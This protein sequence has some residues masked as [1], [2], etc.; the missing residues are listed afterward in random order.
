MLKRLKTSAL[1][2]TMAVN[3][4]FIAIMIATGYGDR[5][6]PAE[7]ATL[8][9]LTLGFPVAVAANVVWLLFWLVAKWRL[10]VVPLLGF[11]LC[12]EPL[13]TYFPIHIP[14][15]PDDGDLEI[16]TF[17]VKNFS[18]NDGDDPALA[19]SEI[20]DYLVDSRADIICLQ[21]SSGRVG[22]SQLADTLKASGRQCVNVEQAGNVLTF[23]SPHRI[24]SVRHIRYKSDANMSIA[25]WLL[26]DG[27]TVVVVN[28]HL[29]SNL[30][31]RD[32]KDGFQNI[33]H[34]QLSTADTRSE[35]RHLLAKLN[36]AARLRGPQA[37]AVHAFVDSLQQ[38]GLPVIV[39]G[40]FN[41]H[42]LSYV[43]RTIAQGL[44]DAYKATGCGPG[45]SYHKSGMYVRIDH[46]LCS[47]DWEPQAAEVDTKIGAS[48][49][50]PLRCWLK[51]RLKR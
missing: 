43:R 3:I 48:D 12:F 14:Q 8:A 36:A 18:G 11:A 19:C 33:V 15:T 20:I 31:N 37:D 1:V 4:V 38:R 42:P 5:L 28:N 44:T 34:G 27:D 26:V 23:I 41:D 6:S 16:L 32:D 49:H 39:C 22:L 51:K 24:L 2:T 9:T 10:A 45:W 21:E 25:A 46:V 29:Q 13:R 7:H 30:L 40:D 47:A 17:N 35:S 50:Y